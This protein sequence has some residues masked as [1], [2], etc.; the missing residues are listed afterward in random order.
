MYGGGVWLTQNKVL[1]GAYI[2]VVSAG[3]PSATLGERGKVAIALPLGAETAGTVVYITASEFFTTP[4]K[5]GTS[6]PETTIKT[7]TEVF[8]HGTEC[9]IYDTFTSGEKAT[10]A[11]ICNALEPYEFN[12]LACYTSDKTEIDSYVSAVK[13]WRDTVGKKCVAVVYN[14]ADPDYEGIINVVTTVNDEGADAHALVAW[15]AGAEAGC[16]VNASCQNMKYDGAYSVKAGYT[17]TE[18]ETFIEEGKFAFH[19]AYGSVRVL[20]DINSL[21]TTTADKGEDFKSNQTMRVCD[22][23]ANDIALL[24]NTRYL[25]IIPNDYA[26]RTNFWADIVK[27]HRDLETIRAIENFDPALVKVEQ[28]NSKK[29]IVVTDYITPVNAMSQLYMTVVVQ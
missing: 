8:K 11:N 16:A 23:V 29:S 22:Q 27:H 20:D 24:F 15:V 18:L 28:G 9:Y 19:I 17:K 6:V 3:K 13:N 1:A 2:N 25:G 5:L 12:V 4:E 26:G 14:A 7:L 21:V 10:V